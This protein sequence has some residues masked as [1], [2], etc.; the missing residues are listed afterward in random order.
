MARQFRA[1]QEL[2]L[3]GKPSIHRGQMQFESPE[4]ETADAD[5]SIHTGRLVPVYPLTAGLNARTVRKAVAEALQRFASLFPETLPV[6]VRQRAR[7]MPAQQAL[8][9][10]HFPD[11]VAAFEEARRRFAFEELFEIQVAVLMRRN[12][13]RSGPAAPKLALPD[14]VRRGWEAA[15]PFPLTGA[16]V[17]STDQ[18]LADVERTTA[19][20]R[21]LQ[22]D[23]GSG[24]TVV[25]LTALLA[26]VASGYQ[27][28]I[29][30]PTELLAEQHFRTVCRLLTGEADP[31]FGGHTTPAWFGERP[32][33]VELLV[34]SLG[35]KAKH[36]AQRAIE[37]GA[38]HIAVG[39]HALIQQD[40][41][42][43]NLGLVVI[44]EQH[45][46]GVVQRSDLRRKG[47]SPHMLVMSAT[48]IPR[49]LALTLYGE[50]DVSVLDEM[51]AGRKPIKTVWAKPHERQEAYEFLRA[52]VQ[53]GRQ[54]FII[55]PLV[56][57]SAVLQAR[58]ATEEYER[59]RHEVYPEFTLD[60][61]HGQMPAKERDAAMR[62]FRDGGSQILVATSVIEVGIDI[63]N[64]T[65]MMIEGA[66]RF[67]LS[68][69]HQFRGRVGRGEH[70][71]Y[72]LLLSD[73][74]SP[75]AEHRMELMEEILDG[76]RLAEEDLKLR[77]PG[78]YFGVRQSG[79]PELR[80]A[81]LGDTP[82]LEQARTEATALLERD[83]SL[84]APELQRLK[85]KVAELMTHAAT[86]VH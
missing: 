56:E 85:A 35:A 70:A 12:R 62:Q 63:P 25:A 13:W 59:L 79:E 67:G 37:Q 24:K 3:A 11:N 65:V 15:L 72:C 39:T 60:L 27:G 52:Q 9:Q 47:A 32:V 43:A 10:I 49:T 7:V 71:S 64:A 26:A 16:Q 8:R 44:D 42:F 41:N 66:D 50:L 4:Y 77:G 31:V 75:E 36:E 19:M 82:L 18:I 5:G 20:A 55:C 40:V 2:V 76:F 14:D 81:R 61:V 21:L 30:A 6:E 33:R 17:R 45:R 34:G 46:F 23:V 1:G 57:G 28:A 74:P 73:D 68:Q 53:Q 29:M 84:T 58:S 51:P 48:P 78:D 69:L 22:G 38:V 54:A 80:A 86:T 83:P